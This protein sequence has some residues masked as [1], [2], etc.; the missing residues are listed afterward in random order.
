LPFL[1]RLWNQFALL[2]SSQVEIPARL[3]PGL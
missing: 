3:N 2:G 1:L